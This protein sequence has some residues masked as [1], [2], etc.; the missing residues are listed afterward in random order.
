MPFGP[1]PSGGNYDPTDVAI[2]GG[3]INNTVI[4]RDAPTTATFTE[5]IIGSGG[6]S[7][8][9]AF[10]GVF[11]KITSSGGL[12]VGGA[13]FIGFD[14]QNDISLTGGMTCNNISSLGTV[15]GGARIGAIASIMRVQGEQGIQ[16]GIQGSIFE[17]YTTTSTTSTNGTEDDLYSHTTVANTLAANGDSLSQV[18]HISLV[19]SATA[20][21][22]FKKYFGGTL[23]FDSGSLTL[24]LGGEF[25]ISTTIIRESSSVV[26]CD[27]SVSSTSAST[28]PYS[29]Y[30]RITALTLSST[31]ILK[32]TGIASGT[33]AASGDISNTLSRITWHPT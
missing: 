20:A 24:T 2:T 3:A 8:L 12:I 27:V 14:S 1:L 30:T 5:I 10:G 13:L 31:N 21:R 23:I 11:A 6:G 29:T 4:G 33:G 7:L 26:R 17:D 32:T 9:P 18:E 16:V 19:S 28:V 22:R 25:S 15:T